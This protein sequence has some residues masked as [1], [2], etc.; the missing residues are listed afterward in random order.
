MHEST[1]IAIN[2]HTRVLTKLAQA[3]GS[4][5]LPPP[6]SNVACDLSGL[7]HS[8]KASAFREAIHNFLGKLQ[9]DWFPA[10]FSRP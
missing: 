10:Y 1:Q 2:F 8:N 4:L 5:L 3:F 6:L 7:T 9:S